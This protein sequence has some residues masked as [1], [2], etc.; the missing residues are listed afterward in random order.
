MEACNRCEC[1]D[2]ETISFPSRSDD[3]YVLFE[4]NI[5]NQSRSNEAIL[6]SRTA[7]RS[8]LFKAS[9]DCMISMLSYLGMKNICQL[10][11]AAT[12][13]AARMTWLSSLKVTNHHSMN[14]FTHDNRSIRWLVTRGIRLESLKVVDGKWFTPRINGIILLG[15]DLSLLR[16]VSFRS[17][18][19]GDGEV[20][21]LAH[22]CPSLSEICLYDCK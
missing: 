16:D 13:T 20:I 3:R 2:T 10:D 1:Q 22:D 15:L 6:L 14:E 21:S 4:A 5:R 17:C 9:N 7:D 18:N 11:I 12:N 19:I 8:Y